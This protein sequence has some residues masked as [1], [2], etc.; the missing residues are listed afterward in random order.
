MGSQ[1]V[2]H[3]W[4]TFTRPPTHRK[5]LLLLLLCLAWVHSQSQNLCH[6]QVHSHFRLRPG[7][8]LNALQPSW[9]KG[10][11]FL[12]RTPHLLPA[13]RAT[14]SQ[15]TRGSLSTSQTLQGLPDPG[16]SRHHSARRWGPQTLGHDLP[17]V[18]AESPAGM[19]SAGSLGAW[20]CPNVPKNAGSG[21]WMG[22]RRPSWSSK[23]EGGWI[24]G[25]RR[26]GLR[27]N[28]VLTW[29]HG[30]PSPGLWIQWD[31]TPWLRHLH[32]SNDG[33]E[34]GAENGRSLPG[35]SDLIMGV[36]ERQSIF[37]SWWQ[38]S[39]SEKLHTHLTPCPLS[40]SILS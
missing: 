26:K 17:H 34:S 32:R 3:N 35:R 10:P 31:I 12:G 19:T 5:P 37:S 28:Q 9:K 16:Q 40:P 38:G 21:R 13:V 7:P 22:R 29:P 15:W 1:E 11:F 25:S 39:K 8:L 24:S 36:P 18:R 14:P 23:E 4:A 20:G 27:E 6:F 2:T 33:S 30:S